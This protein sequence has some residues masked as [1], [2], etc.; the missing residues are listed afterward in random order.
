MTPTARTLQRCKK[1]GWLAGVTERF[2]HHTKRRH[3]LFGF[4]DIVTLADGKCI[5]IQATSGDHVSHRV[6]KIVTEC[7]DAAR[8]WLACGN[9]IEIWGWRKVKLTPKGKATRWEPRVVS[10]TIESIE[11]SPSP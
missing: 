1:H 8:M 2:N 6:D 5:G 7:G 11:S 10:V 4:I 9:L 3:D